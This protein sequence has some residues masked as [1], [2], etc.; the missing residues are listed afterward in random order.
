MNLK[1]NNSDNYEPIEIVLSKEKTPIAYN[2]KIH[3]LVEQEL[4][5]TIEIAERENPT[6]SLECE[7]YYH[8]DNGVFAVECGACEAGTVYSPYTSELLLDAD[9]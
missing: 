2:N 5:P 8:K 9:E 1:L 7:I 6:I 4:Y 3:E